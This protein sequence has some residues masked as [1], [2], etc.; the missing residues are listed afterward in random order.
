MCYACSHIKPFTKV[1][2]SAVTPIQ[3]C[4]L[5]SFLIPFKSSFIMHL[6]SV[7]ICLSL[8][9][10]LAFDSQLRSQ[11]LQNLQSRDGLSNNKFLKVSGSAKSRLFEPN[12]GVSQHR[13]SDCH[14]SVGDQ[15]AC[16]SFHLFETFIKA[17][18]PRFPSPLEPL[19]LSLHPPSKYI[20]SGGYTKG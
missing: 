16:T 4:I 7:I 5:R 12:A 13:G 2:T 11:P 19:I 1:L 8:P 9:S 3:Y 14:I 10:A 20:R 15:R 18:K 6:F 17:R